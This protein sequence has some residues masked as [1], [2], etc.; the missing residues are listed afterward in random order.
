MKIPTS[1]LILHKSG[2]VEINCL[3]CKHGVILPLRAIPG[4]TT[5]KKGRVPMRH[6]L[7][8]GLDLG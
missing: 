2:D 6:T 3:H 4:V 5:L 8:K 1:V 7:R